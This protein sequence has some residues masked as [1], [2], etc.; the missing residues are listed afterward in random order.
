MLGAERSLLILLKYIDRRR[1]DPIVTLPEHGPL[2]ERIQHLNIRTYKLASPSWVRGK[3][4]I[5]Y[6]LVFIYCP[7][8]E[9]LS[10]LKLY[11][12]VKRENVDVIY[13][14][15]IVNFSGA[16]AAF[17]TKKPHI[18]HIREIIPGDPGWHSFLSHKMLFRFIFRLSQKIIAN[19]NATAS[20]FYGFQS[21]EKIRIIYNA[22]D[23]DRFEEIS[24]S[25]PNIEGATAE[26][27]LV[28]L[29]GTLQKRKAQDDAIRAVK[30]AKETIPNIKLLLVGRG[31]KRFRNYLK[32]IA[33]KLHISENVIF[34]GY[35][36]DVPQILRCCKV[37]LIPSW[38]EGF[39]RAVIEG[40]AAGIP[41]I[42]ANSG[43]VKEIIEDNV[44]GYLVPPKNPLK[45]AEKVIYLF[46]HP[47]TAKK[48]GIAGKEIVKEK[49]SIQNYT[50]GIEGII[51][52]VVNVFHNIC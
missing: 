15:T 4:N 7:I 5:I 19:S 33:S 25:F 48:I 11:R 46:R 8:Q 42:G 34:T 9:I 37:V 13:T 6:R 44:T 31:A 10:L 43:G 36:D 39:G 20:Q 16:I 49:F 51:E 2:K 30:A 28:A 24:A 21:K 52:E 1:F 26:D 18:W 12:I 47:D 3:R 38:N 41:V 40:M 23:I 45:I 32:G 17:I 35:R 14:N 29:V 50:Q 27:W 22:V